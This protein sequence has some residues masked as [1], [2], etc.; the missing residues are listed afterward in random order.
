MPVAARHPGWT[1]VW[2]AF[3][4]A[5][6]SWGTGF[7]GPPVFLQTLHATRGWSISVISAAI[8]AHFFTSA[9][10]MVFLPELHRRFGIANTTIGG[11]LL[12]ALGICAWATAGSPWQMYPAAILTGAG[13]AVTSVAAINAMIA[14]WFDQDRPQALSLAYNGAS[15]GGVVVVPVWL[16]LISV[17]GFAGAAATIGAAMVLVLA[18]LAHR[19]LRRGPGDFGLAPDGAKVPTADEALGTAPAP[20]R[21]QRSALLRER[22]FLTMSLAF[23][24]GLFAQMGLLAHLITQ[25]VPVHGVSMAAAAMSLTTVCAVVGRMLLGWLIGDRDRRVAT[26]ANF[27]MQ[28]VGVIFL[29]V[30]ADVTGLILGCVLFGL[31]VGNLVTLPPLIVQAEFAA[32]DVATAVALLAAVNQALYAFA[33]GMFGVLRDLTGA[34]TL[35]FLLAAGA[36]VAAAVIILLG[37][38]PNVS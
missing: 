36:Q 3:T 27:A 24:V 34:Y 30:S 13:W 35:P 16:W 23:A 25:L 38:R 21:I 14:R 32:A 22:R 31:G 7:Y 33:P 26:A 18:P 29:A 6:F 2:V 12:S 10:I 5:V 37:R 8:T 11:A 17:I 20:R 28:S 1:V 9:G 19:Y 15:I 4:V